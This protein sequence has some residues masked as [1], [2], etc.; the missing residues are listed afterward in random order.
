MRGEERDMRWLLAGLKGG[1]LEL[2]TIERRI[3][4]APAL[5]GE[6]AAARKRIAQHKKRLQ[7]V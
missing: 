2:D 6:L 4:S 5:D 7:R 3:A 1:L